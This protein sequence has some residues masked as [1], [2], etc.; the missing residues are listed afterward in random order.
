MLPSSFKKDFKK[1]DASPKPHPE[2]KSHL[3]DLMKSP[4]KKVEKIH[5]KAGDI[6]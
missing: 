5:T 3:D 6:R 1:D 4:S 2:D